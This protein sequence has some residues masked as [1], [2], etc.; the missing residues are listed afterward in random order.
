[1]PL[2]II[3]GDIT[4]MRV[5]AVINAANPRLRR[6]GGVCGAIFRAAGENELKAECELIGRCEV[7]GAV[8]TGGYGLPARFIIHAVGPVWQGGGYRE[9]QLLASCYTAALNLA[10][11]R[12]LKSVA[13]PLISS[14]IYG[15]PKEQ[16]QAVAIG[17]IRRF[18]RDRDMAVFLV[19]YDEISRETGS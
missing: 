4:K 19:I 18:L 17:A 6:G 3:R 9:K 12:G 8:I 16:A 15:Y 10:A 13:F 11:E 2:S 7:G 1:M 5:D 14:G